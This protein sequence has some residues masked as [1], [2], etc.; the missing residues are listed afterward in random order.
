V[1][2]FHFIQADDNKDGSLSLDE[3]LNHEDI[4]YSTVY[5]ENNE[6]YDEDFHDEL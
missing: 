5:D 3:M 6:D 2:L 1:P 4:F